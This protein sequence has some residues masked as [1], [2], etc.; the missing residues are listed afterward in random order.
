MMYKMI[1]VV[2]KEN[3]VNHNSRLETPSPVLI[4]HWLKHPQHEFYPLL[5]NDFHSIHT[6]GAS[7]EKKNKPS[8]RPL[9]ILRRFGG[10]D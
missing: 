7:L 4:L 8:G 6:G 2:L 1:P 10:I 3:P 5:I 9:V